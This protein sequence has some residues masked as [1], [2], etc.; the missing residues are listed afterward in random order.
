MPEPAR[1]RIDISLTRELETSLDKIG[2]TAGKQISK[3]VARAIE[4]DMGSLSGRMKYDLNVKMGGEMSRFSRQLATA[5]LRGMHAISH[6]VGT[7]MQTF[8]ATGKTELVKGMKEASQKTVSAITKIY[9][10]LK[11]LIEVARDSALISAGIPVGGKFFGGMGLRTKLIAGGIRGVLQRAL[12][13]VVEKQGV[14]YR[15]G[16]YM[17]QKGLLAGMVSLWGYQQFGAPGLLAGPLSMLFP[18]GIQRFAA[19][20]PLLMKLLGGLPGVLDRMI[21]LM[22]KIRQAF[23]DGKV[24]QSIKLMLELLGVISKTKET[25]RDV[26]ALKKANMEGGW[27]SKLTRMTMNIMASAGRLAMEHKLLASVAGIGGYYGVFKPAATKLRDLAWYLANIG[28]RGG[29]RYGVKGAALAGRYGLTGA[30]YGVKGAAL[31]GRYGLR[32]VTLAGKY[33]FKG[34]RAGARGLAGGLVSVLGSAGGM[35]FLDALASIV[36]GGARTI[37]GAEERAMVEWYGTK[38]GRGLAS[39][40]RFKTESRLYSLGYRKVNGEWLSPE[41]QEQ[42]FGKSAAADEG[43]KA[44]VSAIKEVL[45]EIRIPKWLPPTSGAVPQQQ[46]QV[47]QDGD[48]LGFVRAIREGRIN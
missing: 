3:V 32:G 23:G 46:T 31:A 42:R 41:E 26:E 6:R 12:G 17:L 4:R 14:Y 40:E 21:V 39:W 24:I 47:V 29:A 15:R 5:Q 7:T 22:P 37:S 10:F 33:G 30:R 28:I 38:E 36:G 27:A 44:I 20:A 43:T 45:Q 9:G 13:E 8:L 34:A 48:L 25:A 35:L 2:Q 1:G 18:L 16:G 19:F 11:N